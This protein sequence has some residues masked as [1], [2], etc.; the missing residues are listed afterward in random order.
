MEGFEANG[1]GKIHHSIEAFG[2]REV[3]VGFGCFEGCA[4]HP[5]KVRQKIGLSAGAEEMAFSIGEEFDGGP[6]DAGGSTGK[7]EGLGHGVM[8]GWEGSWRGLRP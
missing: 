6:A 4:L 7:E 1:A 3:G 5:G 2:Q 8:R